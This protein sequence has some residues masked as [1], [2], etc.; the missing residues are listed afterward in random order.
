MRGDTNSS[1]TPLKPGVGPSPCHRGQLQCLLQCP[2]GY[3]SSPA[4]VGQVLFVKV[5]QGRNNC[6][7]ILVPVSKL[8]LRVDRYHVGVMAGGC[9]AQDMSLGHGRTFPSH[10][11]VCSQKHARATSSWAD[12]RVHQ[13]ARC[14]GTP[15]VVSVPTES[16][17]RRGLASRK[18]I[19]VTP[20]GMAR[21]LRCE[22]GR[23]PSRKGPPQQLASGSSWA[24]LH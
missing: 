21:V 13:M 23:G 16:E 14:S 7:R 12:T 6:A 8:R 3:C 17:L 20:G 19:G 4:P 10:L 9:P 5:V 1:P 22:T 24:A 18:F 15:G 11:A 2:H